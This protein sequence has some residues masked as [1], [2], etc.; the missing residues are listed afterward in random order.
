MNRLDVYYRALC[1][2]RGVTAVRHCEELRNAIS[3]ASRENDELTVSRNICT[4]E[5]DWMDTIEAGL[6]FV[7]KAI[8]EERQFIHSNGEV[9]PIE[10]VKRVSRESVE[11]LA[12][13][14][15]LITK[16]REDGDMIPDRLYSVE[17]LNDYTVYENRF[18]YMLL[19]YLRDF[20]TLRYERILDLSNRYDGVLKLN[21]TVVYSNRKM[22]YSVDLHEERRN[23]PVLRES[24][25]AREAIDRM[26]LMLK[27]VLSLLSTPLMEIAGK[28]PRL[29]PPITKTNV[30]KMDNHFRGA[31]ALYEYLVSYDRAGYSVEEKK[32]SLAPFSDALADELSEAG[33]LLS[34]LTYEYGLALNDELRARYR[35]AENKEREEELLRDAHR[36]EQL[37]KKLEKGERSIEEYVLELETHLR[38]LQNENRQ[39]GAFR[40]RVTEME[41]R[42]ERM[43]AELGELT[44]L[45]NRLH[46]Q[47]TEAEIRHE[48]GKAEMRAEYEDRLYR[49]IV[50]HETEMSML[51]RECEERMLKN[52]ELHGAE[53][54]RLK[55]LL[56]SSRDGYEQRL[57]DQE[58]RYEEKIRELEARLAASEEALAS[59]GKERDRLSE[60]NL[61]CEARIKALRRE[62]GEVFDE[63]AFT[64]EEDFNELERELDAFV[65]FYDERF[66]IAKKSIRKKLLSYQS[67]KGSTKNK[68]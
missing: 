7:E 4:V 3:G 36:L 33:C 62:N 19:C 44:E 46:G 52:N 17:K 5:T 49:E 27:S 30:L 32:Q 34:F 9:M 12:R 43:Q 53:G 40:R 21:K 35:E 24:N 10:K 60:Q 38:A 29:K 11:H 42:E 2:Y 45:K 57:R 48:H 41:K 65:K 63:T 51:R 1:E 59:V 50:Q 66:R 68:L 20:I 54:I 61:V 8:R 18:L 26:D 6:E 15:N 31:M 64:S 13:H 25:P 47:I 55:S 67:L 28:A 37:K 56:Q 14:S 16:E 22:T 23:D 39:L 58:A